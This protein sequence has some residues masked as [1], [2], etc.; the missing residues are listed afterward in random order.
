MFEVQA[1]IRLVPLIL[2][3]RTKEICPVS[4]NICIIISE[5]Q[6]PPINTGN[7]D[8]GRIKQWQYITN[9]DNMNNYYSKKLKIT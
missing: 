2:Y 8:P 7:I 5:I 6:P 4:N 1:V 3:C 9:T